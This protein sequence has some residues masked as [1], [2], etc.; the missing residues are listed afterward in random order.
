[1]RRNGSDGDGEG[2]DE[3]TGYV[4]FFERHQS[5]LE[6]CTSD[7]THTAASPRTPHHSPLFCSG[8][9]STSFWLFS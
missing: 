2:G 8:H 9:N 4:V 5:Y 1:V 6:V 7:P 3:V